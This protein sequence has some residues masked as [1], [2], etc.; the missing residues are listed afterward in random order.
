[1]KI[2]EPFNPRNFM[3]YMLHAYIVADTR[4]SGDDKI[5]FCVCDATCYDGGGNFTGTPSCEVLAKRCG[6]SIAQVEKSL[7]RLRKLNAV[8]P[9]GKPL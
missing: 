7:K 1:M 8:Y 5:V 6:I 3:P 2:G 4:L 9:N